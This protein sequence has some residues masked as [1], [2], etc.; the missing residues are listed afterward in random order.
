VSAWT[1]SCCSTGQELVTGGYPAAGPRFDGYAGGFGNAPYF[2]RGEVP[3]GRPIRAGTGT[4]EQVGCGMTAGA[5][6][7]PVWTQ[8][9][10]GEYHIVAVINRRSGAGS[11]SM[12][13]F[14]PFDDVFAEFYC[15]VVGC[16]SPSPAG[17][18]SSTAADLLLITE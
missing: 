3:R 14:Q 10:D 17:V 8:F 5:S 9:R 18:E 15:L 4:L 11:R 12:L 6:G 1:N 16:P 7:G 13:G 2:C